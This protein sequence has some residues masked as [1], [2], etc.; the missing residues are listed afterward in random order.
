[1]SKTLCDKG[2]IQRFQTNVK[3]QIT[4]LY[5]DETLT[6][7][8]KTQQAD[9]LLAEDLNAIKYIIGAVFTQFNGKLDEITSR[10]NDLEQK[11][12]LNISKIPLNHD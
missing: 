1:M 2:M 4:G 8:D 5:K 6:Y 11:D 3:D 9:T 10:L 12:T 7:L